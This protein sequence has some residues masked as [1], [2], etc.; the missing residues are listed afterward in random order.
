M[1]KLFT[2]TNL[3]SRILISL[4]IALIYNFVISID[5]IL[6]FLIFFPLFGSFVIA[7]LPSEQKTL[8]KSIALLTSGVVFLFSLSLWINFNK[9]LSKF[10]FTETINYWFPWDSSSSTYVLLGVDGI[11]LFFILF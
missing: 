5:S 7:W 3:F 4:S 9:S 2:S 6:S 11:S 1:V 8:I 10:Q